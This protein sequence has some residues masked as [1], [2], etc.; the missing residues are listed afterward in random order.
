[1]W[2]VSDKSPVE[3][4]CGVSDEHSDFTT[5]QSMLDEQL[6]AFIVIPY[7]IV[8]ILIWYWLR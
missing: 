7:M 5:A 4:L 2:P 8:Y 1:M 6:S 3:D